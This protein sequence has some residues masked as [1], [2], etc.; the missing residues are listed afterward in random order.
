MFP[1]SIG[2]CDCFSMRAFCLG[3]GRGQRHLAAAMS[4]QYQFPRGLFYGGNK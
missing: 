3:F 2:V 4:G 1:G